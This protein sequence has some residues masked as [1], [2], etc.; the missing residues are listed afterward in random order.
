MAITIRDLP[1]GTKLTASY[2]KQTYICTVEA[3]EEGKI[4][5][6]VDVK[7]YSSP[8]SAGSAVM[9]GT[10]CNGWRFWT[11]AGEEPRATEAPVP[12]KATKPANS[13]SSATK[14]IK[15]IPGVGLQKG[16]RRFWCL[17][18]QKSFVTTEEDPQAC[19]EG[20]RTDDADLTAPAA[21]EAQDA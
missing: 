5:F 6:A 8:S 14:L 3:G 1:V 15:R 12:A 20:H 10:A 16:E 7:H 13:K 11:V 19:P 2:K 9:N 18:C 17:A 21:F 4:V